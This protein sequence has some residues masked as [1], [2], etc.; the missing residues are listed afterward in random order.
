[1][2]VFREK[3]EPVIVTEEEHEPSPPKPGEPEN[4]D[5]ESAKDPLTPEESKLEIWEGENRRKYAVDYFDIKN[6][7]QE[8]PLNMH[9]NQV[10]KYIKNLLVAKGYEKN[11]ENYKLLLQEIEEEIGSSRL[12][13][14]K[15]LQKISGYIK[16]L[17]R[18]ED[19]KRKREMFLNR[20]L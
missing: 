17:N 4:P 19:A 2:S 1:M 18:L 20:S 15:R 9:V 10:D 14:F 6:I 8:F 11:I 12:E 3:I 7:V 16:A 5:I 13:T